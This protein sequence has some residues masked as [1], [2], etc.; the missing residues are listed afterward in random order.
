MISQP[1]NIPMTEISS[2]IFFIIP[3]IV[4]IYQYIK[5]GIAIKETT[6][7]NSFGKGSVHR[8]R[9]KNLQSNK[10]IVKMLSFVVLGFFAC[11]C[12]FHAQ[13]LLSVY[14]KDYE[15]FDEINYWMYISS[16]V[17]YYFSSTLN[18]ILY[19][20][21]SDRMRNAF[22]E[23]ICGMK[24]K[25]RRRTTLSR[26]TT[27]ETS[28]SLHPGNTNEEMVHFFNKGQWRCGMIKQYSQIDLSSSLRI[29]TGI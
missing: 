29:E 2:V 1:D 7:N 20:V 15:F 27:K 14:L 10:N 26:N 5:M 18:P 11:W 28:I 4:I 8:K 25:K 13:R 12:P 19:N 24:K 22:K 21:M 16:G 9:K 6:T 3:M 17:F 23:V